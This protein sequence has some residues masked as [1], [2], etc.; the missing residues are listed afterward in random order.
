MNQGTTLK[1]G[2]RILVTGAA[3]FIGMHLCDRLLREGHKVCGVDNLNDYY[4]TGL[5]QD[6][7]ALLQGRDGF[8]F[9]Q[10]DIADSN[11]V[12]RLFKSFDPRAVV[13][14][15][16]QAGVRYSMERPDTYVSCNLVGFFN[17]I[18]SAK[19]S[20]VRHLLFASSSSVYGDRSD[21]PFHTSD[22]VDRPV[23][24]YAATKVANE[25]MAHSYAH[26][27]GLPLTG[28]RFFTVYG[29]WGRPDMAYYSFS[30]DILEGEPITLFNG[31]IMKRD[32]TFID[33]VI[34]SV[35]R[36]L[37]LPPGTENGYFQ[38][39][40]VG[41]GQTV[42]VKEFLTILESLLGR[43]ALINELPLH[44]G[45]VPLTYADVT[46]LEAITG[47]APVVSIEDGLKI[48]VDWFIGYHTSISQ[49]TA[50]I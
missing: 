40:N 9:E 26:I 24:F 44:P 45:D 43:K 17:I 37:K 39:L 47:F 27:H 13:H 38:I 7:L 48:F 31:G 34:E 33:D 8:E 22:R 3:G 10:I 16:A 21:A 28:L 15:A 1:M 12:G 14:L 49:S 5:K 18:E 41:R 20:G 46:E 36:L 23:S 11:A 29:P 30:K 6:R 42:I 19:N 25:L 32:F 50:A 35:Y 4:S 2:T